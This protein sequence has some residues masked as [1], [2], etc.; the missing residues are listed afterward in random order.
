MGKCD[1]CEIRK[2][3]AYLDIHWLG[4]EDCPCECPVEEKK[5]D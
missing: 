5:G 3:Y 1:K 2:I 4:E